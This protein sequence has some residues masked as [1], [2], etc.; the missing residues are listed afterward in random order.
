[1]TTFIHDSLVNQIKTRTLEI[2]KNNGKKK[3]LFNENVA[4]GSGWT[5]IGVNDFGFVFMAQEISISWSLVSG[6][7]LIKILNQIKNN[8]FTLK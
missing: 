1:M 5:T 3:L 6:Q 7:N 8:E 2:L 4:A